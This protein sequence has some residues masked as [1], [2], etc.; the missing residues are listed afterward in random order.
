MPPPSFREVSPCT[1]DVYDL[2]SF[3]GIEELQ[4]N[5]VWTLAPLIDRAKAHKKDGNGKYLHPGDHAIRSACTFPFL[6]GR[7]PR[8]HQLWAVATYF[9]L[10]YSGDSRYHKVANYIIADATGLGKT[11]TMVMIATYLAW[12]KQR[13]RDDPT[14][15]T[16]VMQPQKA[17]LMVGQWKERVPLD[18]PVCFHP[19]NGKDTEPV[20]IV[21][22][23]AALSQVHCEV[24]SLMDRQHFRVAKLERPFKAGELAGRK[25][26]W[27][28]F[29]DHR[30][31]VVIS[32]WAVISAEFNEV[33]D[34]GGLKC[35]LKDWSL[36]SSSRPKVVRWGIVFYDEVQYARSPSADRF[37]ATTAL[38]GCARMTF[39]VTATP[40]FNHALDLLNLLRAL[41]TPG[42]DLRPLRSIPRPRSSSV[43]QS[44]MTSLKKHYSSDAAYWPLVLQS[45]VMENKRTGVLRNIK[46]LR[47]NAKKETRTISLGPHW[48]FVTLPDCPQSKCLR[49]K[50]G[51]LEGRMR[52]LVMEPIVELAQRVMLRRVCDTKTSDGECLGCDANLGIRDHYITL[53]EEERRRYD[54][55]RRR[56][57]MDDSQ[58]PNGLVCTVLRTLTIHSHITPPHTSPAGTEPE[59]EE[60]DTKLPTSKVDAAIRIIRPIL[61]AD[62]ALP[63]PARRKV[64]IS[65]AW[66]APVAKLQGLLANAGI[67]AAALNG[68]TGD[69]ERGRLMEAFQSDDDHGSPFGPSRVLII[70]PCVQAGLNFFRANVLIN[71]DPSWTQAAR[72]QTIG[73]VHRIGQTRAVEVHNLIVRDTVDDYLSGVAARKGRLM[74]VLDKHAFL[75]PLLV[76]HSPPQPSR[77]Q[78]AKRPMADD[79]DGRSRGSPPAKRRRSSAAKPRPTSKR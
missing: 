35:E 39:G 60:L 79:N 28:Q 64:L 72:D 7:T 54:R 18:A 37:Q 77:K 75:S 26:F 49:G 44:T 2:I 5:E 66:I 73:R 71:L 34:D 50:W 13:L 45:R 27:K 63:R 69:T 9:A 14:F 16:P 53:P 21:T 29:G 8:L 62:K 78:P 67:P 19:D 57:G 74:E 36:F 61:A 58:L 33:Y 30:V 31:P 55:A 51:R 12:L 3:L 11:T 23:T 59:T 10:A 42:N 48:E 46:A 68:K 22:P 24:E 65:S 20:L 1:W 40:V 76:D 25:R 43:H 15:T 17:Y 4:T 56:Q 32:T 70:S 52:R 41:G 47:K 6:T 38:S